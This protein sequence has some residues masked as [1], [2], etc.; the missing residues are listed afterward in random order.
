MFLK[1]PLLSKSY[2][3]YQGFKGLKVRVP[4]HLGLFMFGSKGLEF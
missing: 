3:F 4:K 1:G 2:R